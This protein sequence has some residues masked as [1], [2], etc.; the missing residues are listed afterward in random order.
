MAAGSPEEID[1][2]RRL[3]YVAMTR[4]NRHLQLMHPIRFYRSQQPKLGDGRSRRLVGSFRIR[5]LIDLSN[6]I[7]L[8]LASYRHDERAEGA[9]E[10]PP[11]ET[12]VERF[13]AGCAN[14]GGWEIPACSLRLHSHFRAT[15][16]L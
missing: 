4:A 5:S 16:A 8:N 11:G 15:A 9:R 14:F 1:A 7:G 10:T 12:C 6:S 3:L 2:E 13:A